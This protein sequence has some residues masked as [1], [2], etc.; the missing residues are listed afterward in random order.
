MTLIVICGA[1]ASG[2][3]SLAL[4]V[5]EKLGGEI[6]NADSDR[7]STRLNSSHT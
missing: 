1:T 2:K 7:K 3:S 6:V 4:D 5:A